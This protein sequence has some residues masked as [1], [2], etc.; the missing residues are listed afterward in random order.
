M[1]CE[2]KTDSGPVSFVTID[3]IVKAAL[4]DIYDDQ[5]VHYERFEF[6]AIRGWRELN[7]FVIKSVK[8]VFLTV[9]PTTNTVSLPPDFIRYSFIGYINHCDE[10]VPLDFNPD[11]ANN[12]DKP[13]CDCKCGCANPLCKEI[14]YD[15]AEETIIIGGNPYTKTV[16]RMILKNSYIEE[17]SIP[18][19]V[20]ENVGGVATITSVKYE[21]SS[22]ELC[23]LEV[24]PCGCLESTTRN[25]R[26]LTACGCA[27]LCCNAHS[28][29]FN[30]FPEA[31][32]IQIHNNT[33]RKIYLEYYGDL[34]CLD[35]EYLVPEIA[36]E[37]IVAWIKWMA[38]EDKRGISETAIRRKYDRWIAAR[39]N[40]RKI[41]HGSTINNIINA[42]TSLPSFAITGGQCYR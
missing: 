25:V 23:A 9:D 28:E 22:K 29:E 24:K 33:L 13:S 41:K 31:R 21:T 4:S 15:L 30:I 27:S 14:K 32:I 40:L 37:A 10:R 3:E 5:Q 35:G 20:Y 34:P 18:V 7:L 38:V 17:S 19:P 8:K 1:S 42:L 12:L 36:F 6:L 39:K 2:I 16:K 26:N 11:I